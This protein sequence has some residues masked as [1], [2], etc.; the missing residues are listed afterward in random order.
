[1]L[2]SIFSDGNWL[3]P[4]LVLL[5]LLGTGEYIAKKKNMPKIDKISNITGYVVMISLLIIYWILYFVTPKDVSLYNVL[6]VTILTF[7]IV[8]DKVLE[9]VKDRLKSKYGKLKVTICRFPLFLVGSH[10]SMVS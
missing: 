2:L 10:F 1:M 8:S 4:L 3:F 7:Y 5:A 9:H 6:L